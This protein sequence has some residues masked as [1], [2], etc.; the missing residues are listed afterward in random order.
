MNINPK[1]QKI[2]YGAMMSAIITVATMF[3]H[4]PTLK[5]YIHLGDAFVILAG[6]LI[7]PIYG[8]I[9]AGI[10]SM[11]ADLLLG[12]AAFA[13]ITFVV[14]MLAA[15]LAGWVF[16]YLKTNKDIIKLVVGGLLACVDIVLLY[17]VFEIFYEGFYAALAEIL[18][19]IM[20]TGVGVLIATVLY[21]ALSA[22]LNLR[23]N[24]AKN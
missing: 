24:N 21:P 5:G 16:K 2:I 23:L 10:G 11:L 14:K 12:Y 20:Q 19:N 15:M 4:Y 17:F 6:V 7:G 13:P 1:T 18:P 9:A 22:I 8:G 3:I